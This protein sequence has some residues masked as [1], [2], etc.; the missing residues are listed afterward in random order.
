MIPTE[1]A[2]K[3]AHEKGLDLVEVSPNAAPP[4]CKI[5]DY[6]KY[7]YSQHK[8]EQHDKK[9][10]HLMKIKEIRL[11]PITDE[12]D[13]QVKLN[14]SR[15]FVARGDKVLVTMRFK[16]REITHKEVGYQVME[17]FV[18]ELQDVAKVENPVKKEGYKL[19]LTLA[20]M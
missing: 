12:H 10:R 5:M 3:M 9:K 16:G 19:T 13:L 14:H 8:K 6:S 2:L 17:R 20:P 4:V 7:K 11:R 15:D 18:K 1:Q